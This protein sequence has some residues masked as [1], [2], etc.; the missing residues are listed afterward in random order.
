MQEDE[1]LV[2]DDVAEVERLLRRQVEHMGWK[3][4]SAHN[5]AQAEKLLDEHHSIRI[6]F[7]DFDVE[8]AE[9]TP[10]FIAELRKSHPEVT[11][12]GMSGYQSKELFANHGVTKF[13]P[14]PWSMDELARVLKSQEA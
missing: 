3:C 10:K 13:L 2:V 9:E 1:A 6:V 12:V 7:L 5:H 4:H 11:V 8:G 14:K